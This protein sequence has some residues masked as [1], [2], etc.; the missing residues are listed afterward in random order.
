MWNTWDVRANESREHIIAW[1]ARVARG[2]P[3][4]RLRH[5]VL[6][7]HGLP[8][9]IELGEGFSRRHLPL[10]E[11]WRG[12]VEKIWLPT[13]LVANIPTAAAMAQYSKDYPGFDVSDGNVFC[14]ELARRAGAFVVAATEIQC[15]FYRDVPPDMMT[16]FEG[17]VLSYDPK[18]RVSWSSRNASR[19]LRTAPDGTQQCVP[20]P[21]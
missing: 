1:V 9:Y 5:L 17:L 6:S 19:W 7:A 14:G 2:A 15:D 11:A 4:G 20:V 18:G 8:G 21:D 12:L 3:G 16:S 13:C 10:F